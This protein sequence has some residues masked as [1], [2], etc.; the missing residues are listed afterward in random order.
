MFAS[1]VRGSAA[2]RGRLRTPPSD[3]DL[4]G[5]HEPLRPLFIQLLH[6]NE[7]LQRFLDTR[8]AVQAVLALRRFAG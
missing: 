7:P 3:V 4:N 1:V 6:G 5:M 2:A 8:H